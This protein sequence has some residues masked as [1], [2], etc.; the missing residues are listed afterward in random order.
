MKIKVDELEELVKK[1][2]L[3]EYKE[4]YAEMIKEIVM[5][6]ELTGRSSHGLL[7]LIKGNFGA[8][9]EKPVI[10]EP[11]LIKK[12]KLSTLIDGK[13][14]TGMLIGSLAS[15]EAIKLAK[16]NGF[17]IV[18]TKNSYNSTGPLSYY[19]EK[20]ALNN[21]IGMVFTSSIVCMAPFNT[22]KALFGTNPIAFGFPSIPNPFIFD[23]STSAITYG[24]IMKAKAEGHTIPPNVAIDKEGIT[25]TDPIEAA[26][27]AILAFDNSYKGSGLA[28]VIE[29]L[30]SVLT[31]ASFLNL[32]YENNGWGNLYMA[33]SPNLLNN[34]EDFKNRMKKLIE[35][36]KTSPTRDGKNIRIPGEKT[37]KLREE[38]LKRGE[39]EVDKNI[40]NTIK[41][42]LN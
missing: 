42:Y 8:F 6:A 25:T 10:E 15:N 20:I 11:K 2:L 1:V 34:I 38:N 33:F 22:K 35:T 4:E 41:G 3:T 13:G 7:R 28:M 26:A 17:G 23:M 27:G 31:G 16:V 30:A 36:L 37:F 12:S 19:V 5:F 21:L 9:V 32:D 40:I 24:T 18:G 29:I 39:I 14:N